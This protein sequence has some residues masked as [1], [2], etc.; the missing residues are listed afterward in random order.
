LDVPGNFQKRAPGFGRTSRGSKFV[1]VDRSEAACGSKIVL[2]R[3]DV[4]EIQLTKAAIRAGIEV[5]LETAE[6]ERT[7]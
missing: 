3:Q 7:L 4:C 2:T 6:L 1:L 5:L